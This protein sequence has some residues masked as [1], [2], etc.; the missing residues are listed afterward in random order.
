MRITS[1][2]DVTSSLHRAPSKR[3]WLSSIRA[4]RCIVLIVRDAFFCA[5]SRRH[6][7]SHAYR[8]FSCLLPSTH[9]RHLCS[10]FAHLNAH[11]ARCCSEAQPVCPHKCRLHGPSSFVRN[12]CDHAHFCGTCESIPVSANDAGEHGRR[13]CS[14]RPSKYLVFLSDVFVASLLQASFSLRFKTRYPELGNGVREQSFLKLKPYF[15]VECLLPSVPC[16]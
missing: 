9:G 13:Q 2:S 12:M 10:D 15:G 1:K 3:N 4:M 7:V 14:L 8:A 5:A 6:P 16:V 11:A